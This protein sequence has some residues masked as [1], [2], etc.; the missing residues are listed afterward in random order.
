M[1]ELKAREGTVFPD[2][3]FFFYKVFIFFLSKMHKTNI[4]Q[5]K[6]SRAVP[7]ICTS[8]WG[9]TVFFYCEWLHITKK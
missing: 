4:K 7:E 6:K 1:V 8:P 3:F 5:Y 2:F 9:G